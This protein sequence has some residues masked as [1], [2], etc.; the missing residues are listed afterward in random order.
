M[1]SLLLRFLWNIPLKFKR[2]FVRA[3]DRHLSDRYPMFKGL[4][5]DWP[6]RNGIP[7]YIR[8]PEERAKDLFIKEPANMKLL[9]VGDK[10]LI[11]DRSGTVSVFETEGLGLLYTMKGKAAVTSIS[12]TPSILAPANGSAC[13]EIALTL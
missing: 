12:S 3:I 13:L 1:S 4:S 9:V 8:P 6:G 2:K 10:L 7:P 11:G 5:E